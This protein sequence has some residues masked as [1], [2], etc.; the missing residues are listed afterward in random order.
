MSVD[1]DENKDQHAPAPRGTYV[2][3]VHPR[4]DFDLRDYR[5]KVIEALER[6]IIVDETHLSGDRFAR[7]RVPEQRDD[8]RPTKGKFEPQH[9]FNSRMR[10]WR[11]RGNE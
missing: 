10:Q 4:S 1:P 9:V 8:P 7:Q 2:L 3:L 5:R 11:A 6:S